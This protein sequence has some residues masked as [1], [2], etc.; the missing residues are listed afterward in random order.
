M[1]TESAT[2]LLTA[3]EFYELPDAPHGGKM[4][5]IC[6]RPVTHMPVGRNHSRIALRV[7]SRLER[8]IE[9]HQLGEVGV[10]AGFRI[11]SNPDTVRAP[12]VHF[13]RAS[14]L[15]MAISSDAFFPGPPDLAVEVVSPGDTDRELDEKLAQY[16]QSGVARSWVVRPEART[17]TVHYPDGASRLFG[18]GA[19]L[20]SDDAGFEVE[21]F[22]LAITELFGAPAA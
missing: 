7:G 12:D 11:S 8:F 19:T 18:D 10:E 15:S 14:R 17:V 22:A 13:I 1:S 5:L 9:A 6:G 16:R 21:G 3:E 4:E 20:T 2:A